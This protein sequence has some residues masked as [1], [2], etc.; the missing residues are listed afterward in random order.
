MK[1]LIAILSIST[2]QL[3]VE[4]LRQKELMQM[5]QMKKVLASLITG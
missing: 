3:L 1:F 4:V 5:N 2:L